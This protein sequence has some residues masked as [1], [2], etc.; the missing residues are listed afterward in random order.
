[1][2]AATAAPYAESVT[3]GR[4]VI[5]SLKNSTRAI[6][7]R[8][9]VNLIYENEVFYYSPQQNTDLVAVSSTIY[10]DSAQ[11][12][13][14]GEENGLLMWSQPGLSGRT[15]HD[16][17]PQNAL[18]KKGT[19]LRLPNFYHV[20]SGDTLR[21]VAQTQLGNEAYARQIGLI[22]IGVN[23]LVLSGIVKDVDGLKS[24]EKPL[25]EVVDLNAEIEFGTTI[26]MPMKIQLNYD[27]F[28][29]RGDEA[30]YQFLAKKF[31]LYESKETKNKLREWNRLKIL[32]AQVGHDD[33]G[34]PGTFYDYIAP[35]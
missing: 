26:M 14:L 20:E 34:T 9:G 6:Q 18:V 19:R 31:Y 25:E 1:M 7:I 28:A 11:R 16:R 5:D 27:V 22:N 21:T 29:H 4:S 13:R 8:G 12:N 2:A 23:G 33:S 15:D 24:I 10:G 17:P 32:Q 3:V 30:A 35:L